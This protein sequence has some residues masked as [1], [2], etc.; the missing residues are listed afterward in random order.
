VEQERRTM[1]GEKVI[2]N[3]KGVN[4]PFDLEALL[5]ANT[6]LHFSTYYSTPTTSRLRQLCDRYGSDKGSLTTDGH[7]YSW[8]PHTFCDYYERLFG[9]CRAHIRSVF[10]CGL[11]TNN[12]ALKSSMGERGR[13]GASLRVWR[14]YFPNAEIY[15]ADIDRTILFKDERI[16]TSYVDQMD[17]QSIAELWAQC[18][19]DQFDLMID[20]G[21]HS[22]EAA[23]T[24]LES[25][26]HKLRAGGV[27]IVEDVAPPMLFPLS[28]F[29][30]E[31]NHAFDIVTMARP[32]AALGDNSL[33]VLR[34]PA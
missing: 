12:P 6:D 13:P 14:D 8:P 25:S 24:L 1:P 5:E 18:P 34:K 23:T 27:Y 28:K 31:R 9:H 20:D 10:E 11:G 26:F 2:I 33:V 22:F 29:L 32:P 3:I 16:D 15:G 7:V 4:V 21:L 19:Q 17:P 30:S